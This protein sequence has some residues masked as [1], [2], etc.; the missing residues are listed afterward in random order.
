MEIIEYL[1]GARMHACLYMPL[2]NFDNIITQAFLSKIYLYIRNSYKTY[3]ELY[4]ALY[5]NKV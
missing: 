3:T 4:I 2:Q 5:N 1:S